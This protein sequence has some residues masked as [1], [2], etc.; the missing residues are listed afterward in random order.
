MKVS[1]QRRIAITGGIG[2]GKSTVSKFLRE[3]GYPV[4]SCDEI[5]REV[6][7]SAEYLQA[8]RIAFSDVYFDE[9]GKIDRKKLAKDVFENESIRKR[10]NEIAHVLIMKRLFANMQERAEEI[11]FAEVPLLFEGGFTAQFDGVVVVLREKQ[12]RVED[13]IV[14]DGLSI[15]EIEGRMRVQFDYDSV[16]AQERFAENHAYLIY[17]NGSLTDLEGEVEEFL[18]SLE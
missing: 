7:E 13:L 18:R 9:N 10:L 5:Y 12:K 17:N 1:K 14:R 8:M 3:K 2:S 15:E 6:M 11:V 16:S 4:F